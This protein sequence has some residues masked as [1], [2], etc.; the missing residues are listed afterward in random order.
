MVGHWMRTLVFLYVDHRPDN[1]RKSDR[2]VKRHKRIKTT[3]CIPLFSSALW[4]S[5]ESTAYITIE[6][7]EVWLCRVPL[8]IFACIC[9]EFSQSQYNVRGHPQSAGDMWVR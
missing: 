8:W 3:I 6:R 5:M 7:V 4:T 2:I 1:P 9:E